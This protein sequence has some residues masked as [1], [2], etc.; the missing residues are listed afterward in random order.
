MNKDKSKNK[1]QDQQP[2]LNNKKDAELWKEKYLRA[3]ADYQNLEKRINSIRDQET[4]FAAKEFVIKIIPV[5]DDIERAQKIIKNEGLQLT[6]QNLFDIFHEMNIE[7]IDVLNKDFDPYIMECVDTLDVDKELENKVIEQ[8][9][10]AYMM[11]G[12]IIRV[13]KVKIGKSN[14][15]KNN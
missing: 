11:Y 13:A 1:I 10:P 6:L 2:V 7:K 14:N 3:L 8:F 9:Q 12:K 4:K 15:I 5:I